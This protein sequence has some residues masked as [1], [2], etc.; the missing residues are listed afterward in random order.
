MV[1]IMEDTIDHQVDSAESISITS[2][3]R[4]TENIELTVLKTSAAMYI[5]YAKEKS[6]MAILGQKI[7]KFIDYLED[8]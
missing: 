8:H 2:D 1:D 6:Y 4:M 3:D 5:S 7:G